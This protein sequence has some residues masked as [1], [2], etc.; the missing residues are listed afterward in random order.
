MQVMA[1]CR[2]QGIGVTVQDIIASK[3]ISELAT[4]VKFSK[5]NVA[6]PTTPAEPPVPQAE[7][8]EAPHR[9]KLERPPV[10]R[11]DD[12]A[13]FDLSPIQ[14][15]YL[16]NV[17]D[18]WRQFNQSMLM[19]LTQKISTEDLT[20]ALNELVK[21]HSMLRARF[22]Q[23]RDGSWKQWISGDID[24]SYRFRSHNVRSDQVES[25]IENSQKFLDIERGPLIAFDLFNLPGQDSQLSIVAHHLVI[26]VVS[27]RIILQDFEDVLN[28]RSLN[29]ENTL[30]F[31]EWVG[32]QIEKAE[33]DI[34]TRVLPI[35][36]IPEADFDY[37]GMT[38]RPNTFGDIVDEKLELSARATAQLLQACRE[39][40]Q[41]DP[42][43]VF[44]ASILLSFRRKFSDRQSFPAIF[45]EGHGR[46]PWDPSIDIS[47]TV[48]WFTTMS[49]VTLPST[50]DIT[51]GNYSLLTSQTPIAKGFP[52]DAFLN[53]VQYIKDFRSR[54]PGKGRPYFAFRTLTDDGKEQF[55]K[56][57]PM[58][59]AFNY[60]GQIQHGE[61]EDAILQEVDGGQS[62]NT[63]SDIGSHV[64]RFA[65]I[66]ISAIVIDGVLQ[67]S[68]S[69]NRNMRHINGIRNWVCDCQR[70]LEDAASFLRR[71]GRMETK[72]FP[73]MPLAFGGANKL[74]EQLPELG[75]SSFDELENAYPC[76]PMQQGILISQVKDPKKYAY[77]S[78]FE[79]RSSRRG[80][81]VDVR[82]L[83]AAWQRVVQR[84]PS[85]RTVFIDSISGQGLMDQVVLRRAPGR[86]LHRE[87]S[88]TNF[89]VV[90]SELEPVT[91]T[92]KRP[93]HRF[94][95]CK[96]TSGRVYGKL[97]I[98]HAIS[99]GSSMPVL[100][101]DLS[102][103]YEQGESFNTSG[104][105]FSDFIAHLQTTPKEKGI[106]YWKDY[107]SGIEPCTLPV[108][109]DSPKP[110]KKENGTYVLNLNNGAELQQ[111]CR[112]QGLTQANVMQ[113]VWGLVLRAYTGSNEVCFGYVASGR[114]VPVDGISEA[115]GAFINMLICRLNLPDKANVGDVLQQTQSDWF[116]SMEYQSCS[117]ADVQH[118]LGLSD[119]NLFNT[120]FTFQKRVGGHTIEDS[121]LSFESIDAH[122]PNEFM[123]SV[124]IEA[125]D[126]TI[127]VDFG[128]LTNTISDVQAENIA[129]TFEHVLSDLIQEHHKDRTVGEI[130]F[131]SDHCSQQVRQ[132]N[133]EDPKIL[134]N[135]VH[136]LFEQQ[137]LRQPRAPAIHSW[138]GTFTYTELDNVASRLAAHLNGL[139]V[140]PDIYVPVLFE[141]TV[142]VVVAYMAIMKAGGA[143]VPLDPAHP[144]SRIRGLVEDV[145][146]NLV[147]CSQNYYEK[148]SRN[149][150]V[151]FVV[152]QQTIRQ[153]A[154][155]PST[156]PMSSPTPNNAAYIIFT[157]GT[158]G[159]PKGTVIEHA[160]ICT[161]AVAHAKALFMDSSSRVLQFA[162]YTFDASIVETLTALIVG[163][164]ICIPS[165]EDRMNDI[166]KAVNKAQA[167]WACL[168]PSVMSTMK[169]EKVP[170][171]KAIAVGGEAMSAK[172]LEEW[173]GGPAILNAYGPT[174]TSVIATASLKV[175]QNGVQVDG[176]RFSIGTTTGCRAWVVDAGNYNKLVPVGAVGE[177]VLEGRAVARGYLNNP[178][179]T[180][181]VFIENPEW[182]RDP[183]LRRVFPVRHRMYRTG[184]LVRYNPDGTI[185]YISRRDTQIKLNGQRIEI[186]EIE[187]HCKAGLPGQTQA[188]VELVTP[189][190][191]TKIKTLAV[192]FDAPTN[193]NLNR[194]MLSKAD[195]SPVD[196][197]L[198]PMTDE[199]RAMAK[200]M[201]T[202][203]ATAVPSYM[204]PHLFIPVTKL[205]WTTSGKLDRNRIRNMTQELSK[206]TIKTYRLTGSSAKRSAA[207]GTAGKLQKLWETV[208]GLGAGSVG[209]ED[210]F[211]RLGGDSLAAM[212]LAG[213]ARAQ[214]I[215]LT[216]ANIFKSPILKDMANTCG[217]ATPQTQ[218]E[219]KPFSLLQG[220]VDAITN[221]V[222]D[223]FR[224]RK[225]NI[226]DI[227]PASSLQEG[228]VALSIKQPGAYV[229]QNVFRLSPQ[230]DIRKLKAA[231]Q[232]VVNDL[233]TLRTRIVHTASSNFLQVV[234]KEETIEWT[235]A[236]NLNDLSSETAHLPPY[237]GGPLTKFAIVEDR[238]S[239]STYFVW[240]IHHALYDGWSFPLILKRV[241]A[242]YFNESS[243]APNV[244]YA[245]FI[246]YLS[247]SDIKE[248]DNYWRTQLA[249]ISASN[250]PQV[251][252]SL[253]DKPSETRTVYHS[254]PIS[255]GTV[256]GDV[257][258]PTV[259]RAA[260]AMV[261]AAH[262]GTNDVCFGETLTGRNINVPGIADIV[263]PTLTTVPTRI[264]IKR[265]TTVV[266]Y[267]QN[268]HQIAA[269]VVPHQHV[270]LQHIRRLDGDTAAAC[271]FQNLLVIQTAE[272][273][274]RD[275]FWDLQ[276]SG[277]AQNFFTYPLVVECRIA[278]SEVETVVYHKENVINSWYVQRLLDQFSFVLKQLAAGSKYKMKSLNDVDVFS[279]EDK[280]T[281]GWWNRRRPITVNEC[282][283]DTFI[284]KAESQPSAPAV[285][286]MNTE[287][288]YE[289]LHDYASRLALHLTTFGVGPEVLVPI[290]LDKSVWTIVAIMGVLIAGGAFVPLDP[291]HPVTRHHEIVEETEAKVVLASPHY[292][293][294][295]YRNVEHVI[296]IEK[297]MITSLPALYYPGQLSRRANP[298]N[299][300]Y[301]IF[302]SGS[303]GRAKGII[304]EH[305]AFSSSSA[306]FGPAMLMHS[307]SRVFQFAS[308][309][310]DASVMEILTTLTTGGC[311]CIPSEEERMKDISGAIRRMNVTW[312]L[313][314]PS[315]ANI[316]DPDAAPSL[317]VLVCGGEAM[318][319]EVISKWADKVRLVNAYGPSESSVVAAVNSKVST[320]RNASCI[321]VGI[322]ATLT[323]ILDPA[324]HDKLAPLGAVGELALEGPTLAREYLKNPQKTAE[325]FVERVAWGSNFANCPPSGRRIHKTGDLVRYNPNGTLEFLGR[326]DSQVKLNG[327]RMELG[328]IEHRLDVDSRV[329]H[330][331]VLMPKN[332][333]CR[334]RLVAVVALDSL[335]S[336]SLSIGDI[337]L[338]DD[339]RARVDI[340]EIRNSLADQLPPFMIPQTWVV[341]K[342]IP[343]LASGKLDR[344]RASS[345][346]ESM[347]EATYQRIMGAEEDD[348]DGP[349][350]SGAAKI[351]QEIW[352]T[353]LN[354]PIEKVK[355][356]KSFLSLGKSTLRIR[357]YELLTV[358]P[359][360]AI[361]SQR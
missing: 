336:T 130:D 275:D 49:P 331:L 312:T 184:D 297:R 150:K 197:L 280:E 306:T 3:S 263:G 60:L 302:T 23:S 251:P 74:A 342:G 124:N 86:V 161:S 232:T 28:G 83:E 101:Q 61:Q 143:F 122:D 205:P 114:N 231:W 190:D 272:E 203:L 182:T 80:Q 199:I 76:S 155:Q 44:L 338:A 25:L 65:L 222:M 351:I 145:G 48:G 151:A 81:H 178:Q 51:Q 82:R 97:E 167:T 78:V 281:V 93:P 292:T 157:S 271:D 207:T 268:V 335:S 146:A 328:E 249:D 357:S 58:E 209:L 287:L 218:A 19:R 127:D 174:E 38:N 105:L 67:V 360:V 173:T 219:L 261:V 107:L 149:A 267:L 201:E 168:T 163:A 322:P 296:T 55:G 177:L 223:L 133:R 15:V 24:G 20:H 176:N 298:R 66:E 235:M 194:S 54:M 36:N 230:I 179:K 244:S 183:R 128:Y 193:G 239:S 34:S 32:L 248:S 46:E 301:S 215:S 64:P 94:T 156:P 43:D 316:V 307:E 294:R 290:C 237:N 354:V 226:Q 30:S 9:V 144:D 117:L 69:Y 56:H 79:I 89:Q 308:L 186:G 37:W 220:S 73:L 355:L 169:M 47:S 108:L 303:T 139:G 27:W 206:E 50:A 137:V 337:E 185:N 253:T 314:T 75:L 361:V 283:H 346:I 13:P 189:P 35:N 152:N 63:H 85:L 17:G 95:I 279:P 211:F 327:Q 21:A 162:S 256:G 200:S 229:A 250:F 349:Q 57:W 132:W 123:M 125:T 70:L 216:F 77:G 131:F 10:E 111:F 104:P 332:G 343:L 228:L 121:A 196:D 326:K 136:E 260:W 135:C 191:R 116:K 71:Q 45:N 165:D 233:D 334:K 142:W 329:R 242:A 286:D 53:A 42:V 8:V 236:S 325:G 289:E 88:A 91:Y 212:Q 181:E 119:T 252:T 276:S 52:D 160:A 238:Y 352:A 339:A 102:Q 11:L 84:H 318:S 317:E 154:N 106:K 269:D 358:I 214:G 315:V 330:V 311:V 147:L 118:E 213:A 217:V 210:S 204:I 140:G 103:A 6:K 266:N 313:L 240:S 285:C 295:F 293:D 270:G 141:K 134:N 109:A 90:L 304:I 87:A 175:D 202:Y 208:L 115:V 341:V 305:R 138:D 259:I 353:V 254:T 68:F 72:D 277:D 324:D 258:V 192:Y 319:P 59:I 33:E 148:A 320:E 262:T 5:G 4:K 344:K 120:V 247:A 166:P 129:R 26:D 278:S 22:E 113:L 323:W 126:T 345:W 340:N 282:I 245:N 180:A 300:A 273:K 291:A 348:S 359:Q 39:Y 288:D 299:S 29:T 241:E 243:T 188:A 14:Q 246:Q 159:K 171:F 224:V 170:S 31:E 227:Y 2:S 274:G 112:K 356:N 221:E 62:V 350:A 1:R 321:G 234:L 99:D 18:E 16:R 309:S 347:D 198:V 257:T 264:Q 265:N 172:I 110:A 98:S 164:C 333:P 41:T 153:L 12:G 40:L 195:G 7:E 284:N 310:F 255:G 158:T 92:D 100:L 187:Y 96:T 225:Y